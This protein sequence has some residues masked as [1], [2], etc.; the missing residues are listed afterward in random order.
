MLTNG[1]IKRLETDSDFAELK[2]HINN[3]VYELDTLDGIDFSD[4][5]KATIEGRARV[6]AKE[7]LKKILEPF[8]VPEESTSDKKNE[9]ASKTGVV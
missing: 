4:K 1:I 6:L 8:V 5:E 7:K 3:T 9:V 2:K